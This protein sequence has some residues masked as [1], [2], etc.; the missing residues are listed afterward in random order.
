VPIVNYASVPAV[1][2]SGQPATEDQILSALKIAGAGHG[3]EVTSAANGKALAVLNVRGKH[4]V[5]AD[6]EYSPGRYSI[7]YRESINLNYAAGDLIHPNYN[8][9][10]QTL[11]DDVRQQLLKP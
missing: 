2:A 6:I 11:V 4:S 8:K 10:V 7:K 5:S 9:W 3:W 1:T